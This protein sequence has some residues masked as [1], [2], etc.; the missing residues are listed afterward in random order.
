M[1]QTT[2]VYIPNT[3]LEHYLHHLQE[4]GQ[5]HI[6]SAEGDMDWSGAA[7]RDYVLGVIAG[8]EYVANH[9]QGSDRQRWLEEFWRLVLELDDNPSGEL[10]STSGLWPRIIETFDG[11]GVG[12]TGTGLVWGDQLL[13]ATLAS[14]LLAVLTANTSQTHMANMVPNIEA[15]EWVPSHLLQPVAALWA[16]YGVGA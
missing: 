16:Q 4:E 3:L 12:G 1:N 8:L 10:A 7:C 2:E 9:M 13:A 11:R 15:Q 5:S 6:L 14:T